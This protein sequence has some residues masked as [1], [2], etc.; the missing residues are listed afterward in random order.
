MTKIE[1]IE[2][3]LGQ[4][5]DDVRRNTIKSILD[6]LKDFAEDEVTDETEKAGLKFAI[7]IIDANYIH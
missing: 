7:Q 3:L 4:V 2:S 5:E 1:R 6:T